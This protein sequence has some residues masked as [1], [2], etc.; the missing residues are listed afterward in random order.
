MKPSTSQDTSW[1]WLQRAQGPKHEA[2]KLQGPGQKMLKLARQGALSKPWRRQRQ[3]PTCIREQV[4][5]W[6]RS[7]GERDG[8]ETGLGRSAQAGR[9]GLFRV[10]FVPPFW[11]RCLSIYYLC[12]RRPPHPS[13]H[14]SESRRHEGEALGGSRRPPQV[15]KLPRRWPRPCPSHHGW[16]CV[17][18]PWWSSGAHALIPSRQLY[19][20]HSI[21]M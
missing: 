4:N 19:I 21:V 18:K 5:N 14:S 6:P 8:A 12:L 16:P 13:I 10:Q 2:V 20:L 3:G 17:V 1:T 7:I 9:P 11:P 15:L